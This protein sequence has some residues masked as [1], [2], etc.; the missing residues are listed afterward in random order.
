MPRQGLALRRL[1]N[2][3]SLARLAPRNDRKGIGHGQ[4]RLRYP[5][6]RE[7]G[8][9]P[10]SAGRRPLFYRPYPHAM[11]RAQG[12]PE[13]R[14]RIRGGLRRRSRSALAR[15]LKDVETCSHIVLLYWMDKSPRNLVLQVPGHYGVQHG[16]FA[17]RSP[18][19]PNP[20]AM[21]VVKLLRVDAG[22]LSVVGSTAWMARHCWTSNP[23]LPPPIAYRRPSWAGT[24]R[25]TSGP[26]CAPIRSCALRVFTHAPSGNL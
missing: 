7:G 12:L 13:K 4:Q 9:A 2:P 5:R 15:G 14:P 26:E 20:L 11:E 25:K 17:L 24:S 3:A 19:R 10:G 6:G 16:T 21:S 1:L 22:R 8:R 23:I 18:A